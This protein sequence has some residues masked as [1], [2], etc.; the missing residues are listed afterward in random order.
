MN[1]VTK[2]LGEKDG[3]KTNILSFPL[4]GVNSDSARR[5]SDVLASP[6]KAKSNTFYTNEN[7][8][9]IHHIYQQKY[10]S[11]EPEPQQMILQLM[12]GYHNDTTWKP[13]VMSEHQILTNQQL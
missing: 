4:P 5:N 12:E 13:T 8:D 2:A 1:E 10:G 11:V 6:N 7:L 9:Y 3:L